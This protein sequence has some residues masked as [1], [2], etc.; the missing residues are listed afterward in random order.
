MALSRD[1]RRQRTDWDD[2]GRDRRAD[3]RNKSGERCELG[4]DGPVIGKRW[5]LDVIDQLPTSSIKSRCRR[6]LR[7]QRCRVRRSKSDNAYKAW[8]WHRN[9]PIC[10]LPQMQAIAA[11]IHI[12]RMRRMQLHH[13][14]LFIPEQILDKAHL[15]PVRAAPRRRRGDM[16]P[17]W[18]NQSADL[19]FT[20]ARPLDQEQAAGT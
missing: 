11:V 17:A 5:E 1:V 3:A 18:A 20:A 10:R 19:E 8:R 9:I 7:K 13:A 6:H 4:A 2:E 16:L 14:F 15:F 12:L